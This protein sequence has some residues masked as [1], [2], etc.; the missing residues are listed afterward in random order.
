MTMTLLFRQRQWYKYYVEIFIDILSYEIGLP[1]HIIT[2]TKSSWLHSLIYTLAIESKLQSK[3]WTK[4][5]Y[6]TKS[7]N[8]LALDTVN[9]QDHKKDEGANIPQRYAN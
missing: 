4:S 2:T 9:L 6:L 8:T 5:K 3:Y 1:N 7:E